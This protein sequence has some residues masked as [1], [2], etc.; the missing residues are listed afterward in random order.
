MKSTWLPILAA[1]TLLQP[2]AHAGITY[3]ETTEITAGSLRSMLKLAAAFSSPHTTKEVSRIMGILIGIL[4][5]CAAAST[6]G[7]TL[8]IKEGLWETVVYKDDGTPDFHTHDCLTQKSFVEMTTK[9]NSHPGCKLTNQNISSHGI[10]I[11]MSCNTKNYQMTT[12]S[13]IEVLDSEHVRGTK[14]IKMVLQGHPNESTTKSAG[15]FLSSSCG[16]IKPGEP[17]ILDK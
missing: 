2:Q 4:L 7:Q 5:L 11:D 6:F 13:V 3:Q 12:H 1:A 8:P 16:K 15:H 9:V 14:T 17:E 10:T